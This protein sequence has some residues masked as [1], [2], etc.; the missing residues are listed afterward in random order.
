MNGR[1]Q[2]FRLEIKGIAPTKTFETVAV[3]GFTAATAL[4]VD[5]YDGGESG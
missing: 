2:N 5:V 4:S 1:E 3:N